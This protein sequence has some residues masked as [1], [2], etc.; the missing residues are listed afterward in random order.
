MLNF[1]IVSDLTQLRATVTLEMYENEKSAQSGTND[2]GISFDHAGF[3]DGI[4]RVLRIYSAATQKP[5][6][7]RGDDDSIDVDIRG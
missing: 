7:E 2:G 1:V 6:Y 5:L 4:R 3:G